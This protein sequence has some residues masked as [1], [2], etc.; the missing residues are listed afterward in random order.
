MALYLIGLD[1]TIKLSSPFKADG[2]ITFQ[3]PYVNLK[4]SPTGTDLL[5][6]TNLNLLSSK[7]DI[8]LQFSVRRT[9]NA[10]VFNSRRHGAGW[11]QEE[12]IQLAGAFTSSGK[13]TITAYD[14]GDRYQILID[15]RT[16]KTFNKR[17]HEPATQ[18]A[19]LRNANQVSPF[20]DPGVLTQ[21]E[22]L[23]QFSAGRA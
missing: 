6:N 5:D 12:S 3:S 4:P 20:S 17:I 16:V 18:A 1:E 21:Y 14:H 23:G 10:I 15:G 11:G 22:N 2:I 8:L 9:E 19:Y 13:T 7:D